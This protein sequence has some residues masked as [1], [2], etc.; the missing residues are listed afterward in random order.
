[1]ARL[2]LLQGMYNISWEGLQPSTGSL[3]AQA[4]GCTHTTTSCPLSLCCE[5]QGPTGWPHTQLSPVTK[6]TA[7]LSSTKRSISPYCCDTLST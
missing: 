2:L 7:I 6:S 3:V 1:V 5:E 4:L